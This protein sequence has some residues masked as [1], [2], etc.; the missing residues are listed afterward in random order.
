MRVCCIV[1][2][3]YQLINAMNLAINYKELS[4]AYIDLF[5]RK[6]HFANEEYYL[7]KIEKKNVFSDIKV[8]S[9]RDYSGSNL[10]NHLRHIPETMYAAD[11]ISRA[12]GNDYRFMS[13]EYDVILTPNCCHFFKLA[14][15]CCTKAEVWC[16]EDGALSYGGFNWIE[17]EVSLLSKKVLKFTGQY[18]KLLPSRVYLYNPKLFESTWRTEVHTIPSLKDEM[19][20]ATFHEI[21]GRPDCDYS[22]VK[23]VFLSQP[24]PVSESRTSEITDQIKCSFISR[25]HPRNNQD[26]HL[27]GMID[28][29]SSQWELICAESIT[30]D[31]VLIGA[32]SSAQTSPKWLFGK[33]PYLIFTYPLY[34]G[35]GQRFIDTCE[36]IV[37]KTKSMYRNPEKVMVVW[38]IEELN[39]S[40]QKAMSNTIC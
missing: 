29:S 36:A 23:V 14:M 25:Y 31:H 16:F 15:I 40:I 1:E 37:S 35:I 11:I 26:F 6:N 13:R 8:F 39:D 2:T 28:H 34:E 19:S 20:S 17:S 38:S 30:D 12:C 22:G 5:I 4:S 7:S 33:E 21:F 9:F 27:N 18:R 10:I 24:S 3:V 32:G